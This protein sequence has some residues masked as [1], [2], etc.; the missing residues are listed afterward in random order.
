MA[1]LFINSMFNADFLGTNFSLDFSAII[2][3]PGAGYF[4]ANLSTKNVPK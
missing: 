2:V 4:L 1:K 3:F